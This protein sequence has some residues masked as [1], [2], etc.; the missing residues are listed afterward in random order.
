MS[1]SISFPHPVLGN[2]DDIDGAFSINISVTKKE[3]EERITFSVDSKV[4]NK[5]FQDL[6]DQGKATIVT[7]VYCPSTIYSQTIQYAKQFDLHQDDVDGTVTISSYITATVDIPDYKDDSFNSAL[8]GDIS[9][10]VTSGD[11]IGALSEQNI[12][13]PKVDE[14]TGLGNIFRFNI[15]EM[16]ESISFF[17]EGDLIEVTYPK[18][19]DGDSPMNALFRQSPW[20]AVHTYIM[21]ALIF[22][23]QS[24]KDNREDF[25]DSN[26]RWYKTLKGIIGED[27]MREPDPTAHAQEILF[28]DGLQPSLQA[29]KEIIAED[30][31]GN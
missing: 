18:N 1:Q 14:K 3:A 16:D 26:Y 8:F 30:R 25:E 11:I 29:Y 23:L 13:L 5:Y 4:E 10:E 2:S 12:E 20:V 6:L 31:N 28:K 7:K 24:V 22:A 17:V 9:F 19:F 15:A 27:A 21:P